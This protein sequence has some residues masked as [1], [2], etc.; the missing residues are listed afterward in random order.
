VIRGR[1]DEEVGH[2]YFAPRQLAQVD[3]A[4]S[5]ASL[6]EALP[7]FSTSSNR[8]RAKFDFCAN[9]IYHPLIEDPIA[10]TM[11]LTHG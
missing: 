3:V 9:E 2:Q 5:I 4:I 11:D 6:R 7:Y 1:E 10:N 8:D